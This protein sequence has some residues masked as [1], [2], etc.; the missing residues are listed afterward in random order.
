MV[1]GELFLTASKKTATVVAMEVMRTPPV[2]R[3]RMKKVGRV[4]SLQWR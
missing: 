3:T 1:L 4:L 2:L